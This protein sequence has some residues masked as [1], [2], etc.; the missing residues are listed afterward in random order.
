M[1][2]ALGEAAGAERPE[3]AA[4]LALQDRLGEDR[5]R[6]IAGAQ[7]EDVVGAVGHGAQPQQEAAEAAAGAGIAGAQ[8]LSA[9][10]LAEAARTSSGDGPLP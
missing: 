2:R 10:A 5:S 9:A 7:E 4:A 6:R 3:A 8:Q 1:D